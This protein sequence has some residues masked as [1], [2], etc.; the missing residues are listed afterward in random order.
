MLVPR[1]YGLGDLSQILDER[2]YAQ[3]REILSSLGDDLEKFVITDAYNRAARAVAEHGFVLLLGEPACGKSTIAAALAVGALD[4]WKCSTVKARDADDVVAHSNPQELKQ[5]FWIDD[6]FGATQIDWQGT[7]RW[8]NAFPHIQAAIRR[9]ARF[10]LTSRTYIYNSA[11]SILKETA[12]PVLR[13]SQVVI[14]VENITKEERRQILYNHIRLGSQP[15]SFK[16]EVKPYLKSVAS[17][18]NFGP[19]IARRLGNP[20]FTRQ[21]DISAYGLEDFVARPRA[22]LRDVIQT[23]DANSRSAIALVFMSGGNLPSPINLTHEEEHA[24]TLLGGSVV[25]IRNALVALN[26]S[27]LI[28]VQQDGRFYWRFKHPTI[29]DAFASIVAENRELLDIYVAGTPV[30]RLFEEVSCGDVGMEGVKVI[31]PTDRYE[32]MLARVEGFQA[33]RRENR[34]VVNRFL[35]F[36]CDCEFLKAFISRN[37]DFV[38][39]LMV[40]SYL[41]AVPDVN[42]IVRLR[43]FGLLP[44]ADRKRHVSTLKRLAVETPDSGVL[45]PNVRRLF[46]DDEFADMM[47][48]IRSKLMDGLERTIDV[49]HYNHGSEDDPEEYF[50]ELKSAL[51]DY[52]EKFEGDESVVT[53]IDTGFARIDEI[54][55]EI[56]S[57]QPE[58]PDGDEYHGG[59]TTYE[60][61]PD[62]RSIFDDVDE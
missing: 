2:A 5:F 16:R 1:I 27:L 42:V 11:R 60:E 36:R 19:E 51:N 29:R 8:N 54:I 20:A 43:E 41:Y 22:L 30:L 25:E 37:P 49:W 45:R 44:E 55:E 15:R 33:A 59:T 50:S 56:R 7:I 58:E 62:E 48:S 13:E 14:Q 38:S 53:R 24:I 61:L 34:D 47:E 32:A 31:I 39:S 12:L 40:Y 52:R 17:H 57:G 23:L 26:G 4:V 21:L 6:A 46:S 28:Q 9:G 10:V 18:K 35:A 3:A